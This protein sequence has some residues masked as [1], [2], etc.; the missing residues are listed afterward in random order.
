[1]TRSNEVRKSR[2]MITASVLI[3]AQVG[4]A[5]L[6]A[7]AVAEIDSVQLAQPL[8]EPHDVIVRAGP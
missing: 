3:Q 1:M 2:E 8:A 5:G 7:S 4:Q 6:V